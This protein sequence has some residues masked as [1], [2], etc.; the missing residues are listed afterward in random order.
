MEKTNS[1]VF[2][3]GLSRTGTTSLHHI[4]LDLG[5]KSVHFCDF[6]NHED[7]D[8]N[9]CREFDAF[10]DTPIPLLYKELDLKYPNSKFIITIRQKEDWLKSMKWMLSEGNRIWEWDEQIHSYH[11]KLYGTRIYEEEKLSNAWEE[12]HKKS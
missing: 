9:R 11:E 12:F 5:L 8:F 3:I 4:L 6:I 1:K 2:C 7:P 10:G